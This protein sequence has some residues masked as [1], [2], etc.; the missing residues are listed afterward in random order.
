VLAHA[1]PIDAKELQAWV[2]GRVARARKAMVRGRI[3][4]RGKG[5]FA[6]LDA[7]KLTG[8]GERFAGT[9]TITGIRHRVSKTGWSTD[10]QFGFSPELFAERQAAARP[11]AGGLLPPATTL[12]I[13][14]VSAFEDDPTGA[15]RVRVLVPGIDAAEGVLWARLTTPDAGSER[16][17]VFFPE[18]GDE[19][20]VGFLGGDPRQAVVLGSLFSKKNIPPV[21]KI[22]ADN[23]LRGIVS[24]TGIAVAL[25][26]EEKP[27]VSITTPGGHSL[28]MSEDAGSIEIV[29]LNGNSIKLDDKGITLTSVK[30]VIVKG[31]NI[32]LQGSKVEAKK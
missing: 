18:V 24:K 11:V 12:Q 22:D 30:D 16:G 10:L 9:S 23:K 19:V 2:D 15:F 25:I 7:I 14:V 4:V 5:D 27:V 8:F 31:T 29:D 6:L 13:G 21:A 32:N 1:A 26:D 3:S 28:T 17:Y 20:V